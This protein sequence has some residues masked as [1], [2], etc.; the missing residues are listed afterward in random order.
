MEKR[1]KIQIL[2]EFMESLNTMIDASGQMV[3]QFEN[4]KFMALRDMLNIVKD[5]ISD[6]IG[7]KR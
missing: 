6:R 3:H 1:G 4:I 7:N 2:S 5:G